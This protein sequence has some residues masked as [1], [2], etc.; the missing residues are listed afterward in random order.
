L[1]RRLCPHPP[2]ELTALLCRLPSI[3]WISGGRFV[4]G[5][6]RGREGREEKGR[7]GRQKGWNGEKGGMEQKK[8]GQEKCE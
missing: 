2:G 8:G 3:I 4:A 6:C 5:E 7:G 1:A